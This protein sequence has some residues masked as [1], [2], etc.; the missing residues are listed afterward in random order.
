MT[1]HNVDK[2]LAYEDTQIRLFGKPEVDGERRMGV[3]LALGVDIAEA[4]TKATLVANMV[5]CQ[6]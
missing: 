2:A 5:D 4:R 6:L 1:F 3:A